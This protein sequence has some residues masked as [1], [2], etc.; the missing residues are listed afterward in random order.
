[1]KEKTC[2]SK[3]LDTSKEGKKK[4]YFQLEFKL[5]LLE[6]LYIT[7]SKRDNPRMA[8]LFPCKCVISDCLTEEFDFFEP[9]HGDSLNKARTKLHE[10][11]FSR[12]V[13]PASNA[14]RVFFTG[15][16]YKNQNKKF[17]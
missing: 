1:M 2:S 17:R 5:Q 7:N 6:D 13:N 15:R 4:K 3:Y 16:E 8:K 10:L 9:V 11:Y 12:I 14:F